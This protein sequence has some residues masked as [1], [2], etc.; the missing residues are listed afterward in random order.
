MMRTDSS[1]HYVALEHSDPYKRP[2]ERDQRVLIV[3][4]SAGDCLKL[5]LVDVL[6]GWT[7]P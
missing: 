5:S 7:M 4:V 3:Q 2:H 6:W 1:G